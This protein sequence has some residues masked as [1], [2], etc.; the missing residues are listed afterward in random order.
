MFSGTS[1]GADGAM[2]ETGNSV[3]IRLPAPSIGRG[4]GG[5][6]R[7]LYRQITVAMDDNSVAR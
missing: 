3:P 2:G 7:L 1:I 6:G 4:A 5:E